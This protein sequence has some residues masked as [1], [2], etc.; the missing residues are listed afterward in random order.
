MPLAPQQEILIVTDLGGSALTAA[1]KLHTLM[2]EYPPARIVALT[3]KST[4][5]IPGTELIAVIEFLPGFVPPPP[6]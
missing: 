2:D 6:T 3:M 4:A 1:Q 5:G